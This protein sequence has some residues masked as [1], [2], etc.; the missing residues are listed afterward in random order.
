MF[1]N[2]SIPVCNINVL[3]Q[4]LRDLETKTWKENVCDK[5]KLRLHKE[6]KQDKDR[7]RYLELNMY[8]KERSVL[9]QFHLGIHI[10]ANR[11]GSRSI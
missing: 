6:F 10:P 8:R 7:E 4:Q 5:P 11:G 9:A 3:G 1:D 2:F